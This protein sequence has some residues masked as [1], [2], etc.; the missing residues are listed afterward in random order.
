[1]KLWPVVPTRIYTLHTI[2]IYIY[3][4]RKRCSKPRGKPVFRIRKWLLVWD[5]VFTYTI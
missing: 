5:S 3:V 4:R 1:M 2:H